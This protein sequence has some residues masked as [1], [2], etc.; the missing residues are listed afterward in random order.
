MLKQWL[1]ARS[2]NALC[3]GEDKI[4]ASVL[5]SLSK[6]KDFSL[7]YNR[8][9]ILGHGY[10]GL[11]KRL[12]EDP[13]RRKHL[14]DRDYD[15]LIKRF[16][17]GPGYDEHPLVVLATAS[18]F[19]E[20]IVNKIVRVLLEKNNV[21]DA[22]EIVSRLKRGDMMVMLEDYTLANGDLSDIRSFLK[23]FPNANK[24]RFREAVRRLITPDPEEIIDA[25][26][27]GR[28]F[29]REM[30]LGMMGGPFV[31]GP[32]GFHRGMRPPWMD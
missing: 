2:P 31:C 3:E 13:D 20:L 27:D 16:T 15:A 9:W 12:V 19:P 21:H 14:K 25:F 1:E 29:R 4:I 6:S 8:D 32:I 26:L 24:E 18:G 11:V 28:G 23:K 5:H 30:M 17:K 10:I 22:Y 7:K